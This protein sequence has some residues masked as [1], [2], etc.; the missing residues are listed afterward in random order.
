[1]HN[2]QIGDIVVW[3]TEHPEFREVMNAGNAN[4]GPFIVDG[5]NPGYPTAIFVKRL[6][7]LPFTNDGYHGP[8]PRVRVS[9]FNYRFRLDPFLD[10]ARK[11]C[12]DG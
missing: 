7:G 3:D 1:M 9:W 4:D 10:A 2:F 11:A 8:E 12:K 5:Q 6:N